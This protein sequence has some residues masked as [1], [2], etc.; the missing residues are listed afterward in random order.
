MY[1]NINKIL[2]ID[3]DI[4]SRERIGR[5][6]QG[7]KTKLW[8]ASSATEAH[9]V[10]LRE[11]PNLIIISPDCLGKEG[12]SL[13]QQLREEFSREELPVM[14]ISGD[15]TEDTAIQAIRQGANDYITKP[16]VIPVLTERIQTTIAAYRDQHRQLEKER[17]NT[18]LA[19]LDVTIHELTESLTG[20]LN[21][22]EILVED[23]AP[24]PGP[25][26]NQIDIIYQ[27]VHEANKVLQLLPLPTDP[28]KPLAAES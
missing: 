13:L 27:Q 1:E 28:Q 18:V 20:A 12:F 21:E 3:A 9:T 5:A 26:S 19:N 7:F 22:L 8:S 2:I 25:A 6:T 24:L 17:I 23:P 4:E 10:L 14:I 11:L 16:F 15:T